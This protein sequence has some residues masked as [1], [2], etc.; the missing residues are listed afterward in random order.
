MFQE[1]GWQTVSR[2][3][4]SH[5]VAVRTL[6]ERKQAHCDC[7]VGESF[8]VTLDGDSNRYDLREPRAWLKKSGG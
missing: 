8:Y 4:G 1:K 3:R 6:L 7:V 5:A 2:R